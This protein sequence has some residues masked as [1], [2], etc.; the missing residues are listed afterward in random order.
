MGAYY[1][2][3]WVPV[4]SYLRPGAW[5]GVTDYTGREWSLH[6]FADAPMLVQAG[7]GKAV[8]QEGTSTI[9]IITMDDD[10]ETFT[11]KPGEMFRV[12]LPM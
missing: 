1:A 3:G 5:V 11:F 8:T 7:T 2:P 12:V 10:G 6:L 9:K 4:S